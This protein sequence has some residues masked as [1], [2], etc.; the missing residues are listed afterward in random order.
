MGGARVYGPGDC[1]HRSVERGGPMNRESVDETLAGL[2]AAHDR[3]AAAM[4]TID[5]H[6]AL[7]YLRGGGLSGLTETRWAA[8]QPE[9]DRLWAQFAVLGDLLERARGLR[10]QRRPDDADWH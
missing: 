9:V 6:P 10:V 1:A 4:F 5:S 8:L 7:A 3:I 2:G